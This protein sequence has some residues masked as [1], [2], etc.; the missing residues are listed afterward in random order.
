MLDQRDEHNKSESYYQQAIELSDDA[1]TKAQAH[2]A[3]A[4]HF[5]RRLRYSKAREEALKATKLN[6][7]LKDAYK[8]I[9]DLYLSSFESCKKGKMV[10]N[11]RAVF[12]AAWHMYRKAGRK[13]LMEVAQQQFPTVEQLFQDNYQEGQKIK[14]GCWINVEVKLMSNTNLP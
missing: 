12:V 4:I 13:D 11:D 10:S 7:L 3:L 8:L 5:H 6:P 14:I 1:L 2:L 9:G